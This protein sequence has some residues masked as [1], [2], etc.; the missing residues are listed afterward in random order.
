MRPIFAAPALLCLA[1]CDD[2]GVVDQSIEH[3]VR[4]SAVEACIAWVPESNISLAAG[5]DGERLCACA[6][7]Q[8]LEGSDL[9]D[10]VDFRPGGAEIRT[11]IAQCISDI[12]ASDQGAEPG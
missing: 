6:A 3:G 9:S 10:L 5:F 4:Q 12:Q 8:M 7:D 11:A 2:G 1:A